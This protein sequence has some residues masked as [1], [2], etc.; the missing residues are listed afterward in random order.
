[1]GFNGSRIVRDHRRDLIARVERRYNKFA[2]GVDRCVYRRVY[3]R[4]QGLVGVDGLRHGR[5]HTGGIPLGAVRRVR[6]QVAIDGY[7]VVIARIGRGQ[8]D[9]IDLRHDDL[10]GAVGGGPDGDDGRAV[11]EG[12]VGALVV[13]QD[14]E[15]DCR[16][17]RRI[18]LVIAGFR[19]RIGRGAL[20]GKHLFL[21]RL[22][23]E[24]LEGDP[25]RLH[26]ASRLFG[27]NRLSLRKIGILDGHRD[28]G[29]RGLGK[30]L[31]RGHISFRRFSAVGAGV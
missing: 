23:Q 11:K 5:R 19:H 31:G 8:G 14:R 24:L 25:G 2:T 20:I 27:R 15:R 29:D 17:F 22:G 10:D 4:R 1:M 3:N 30:A 7:T 28:L 26:G 16:V 13:P 9:G 21:S 12:A 6:Q 18:D